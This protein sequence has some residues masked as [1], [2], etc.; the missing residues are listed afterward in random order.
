[1]KNFVFISPHFPDCFWKFCLALKN[2][3]FCVLGIGDCP[4][5]RLQGELK[6]ALTEY[7]CCYDMENY[8][9]EKRAVAY[10]E[11]KY[12]H[13][14]FLE[15]NNEFWLEKDAMLRKDFNITTGPFPDEVKFY[16]HKSLQKEIIKS[17]GK[18]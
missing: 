13:I 11:N 5:D 3:G 2:R 18:K 4:Y 17:G 10:F 7:Y 14:D 16:K 15:S 6:Y 8:E 12:G 1:M 9:N